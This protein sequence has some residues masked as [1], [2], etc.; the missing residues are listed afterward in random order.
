MGGGEGLGE[1]VG[2]A[3]TVG[4]EDGLLVGEELGTSDGREVGDALRERREVRGAEEI[5][6]RELL[7]NCR[8]RNPL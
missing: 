6:R 2:A 5:R 4:L 1:I 3:L 8:N 7:C